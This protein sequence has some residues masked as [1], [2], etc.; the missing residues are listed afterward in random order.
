MSTSK[1]LY[2]LNFSAPA[3]GFE[4]GTISLHLSQSFLRGWTISS[5]TRIGDARRFGGLERPTTPFRDSLYAFL[6][7]AREAW[8]GITHLHDA[9]WGFPE[10]TSF[11]TSVARGSCV[12]TGSRSTTELR[13]NC[14][15]KVQ[16][17]D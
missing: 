2:R 15:L 10:F 13:R 1:T 6:S 11:T 9:S 12:I 16:A 14:T 8:L 7:F 17:G 3:P 4:P 5:S